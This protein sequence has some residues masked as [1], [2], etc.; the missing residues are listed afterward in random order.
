[1]NELINKIQFGESF[2]RMVRKNLT[3]LHRA[4]TSTPSN[5]FGINYKAVSQA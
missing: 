2:L 3:G 1:M 5:T 4:L